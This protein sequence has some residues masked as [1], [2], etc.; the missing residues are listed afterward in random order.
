MKL[1]M[2]PRVF[3]EPV[4]KALRVQ[5]ESFNRTLPVLI[6][7]QSPG[8]AI[9]LTPIPALARGTIWVIAS[10]FALLVGLMALIP[11]DRVVV[12]QGKVSATTPNLLYQPLETAI[13]KSINVREGQRVKSGDLLATLDPTFTNA[14]VGNLSG[15]V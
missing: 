13:V 15:Q 8:E 12:A 2:L 5:D 7:F 1:P 6:E 11:I 3:T 14:D 4:S 10:L 9:L